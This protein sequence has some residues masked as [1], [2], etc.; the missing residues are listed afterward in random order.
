MPRVNQNHH[1]IEYEYFANGAIRSKGWTLF[2]GDHGFRNEIMTDI[3]L[4]PNPAANQIGKLDNEEIR[5]WIG[6]IITNLK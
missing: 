1:G 2:G 4:N 6:I 3:N 5:R